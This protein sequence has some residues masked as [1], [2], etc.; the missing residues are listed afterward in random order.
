MSQSLEANP[1][2]IPRAPFVSKV[3]EYAASEAEVESTLRKFQEMISKYKYMQG[4]LLQRKQSLE[5][6]IPDIKKTLEMVE[7]LITGQD[8]EEPLTSHYELNDTLYAHARL[9]P[10]KDG[11]STVYL[12]LGANVMLEYTTAEAQ[13][14]LQQKLGSAK[15]S[16]TQVD[17]D[18]EFLREQITTMEVNT[19]RVYNHD[20]K[21]RR[22]RKQAEGSK[23][24]A[25]AIAGKA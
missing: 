5:S 20:V 23:A 21:M 24:G 10:S 2:G 25:P 3:E 22:L 6:K 1:R 16:L 15:T 4:H 7:F 9:T 12:W 13:T 17:E 11:K 18:L 14:L 19:A 8:S